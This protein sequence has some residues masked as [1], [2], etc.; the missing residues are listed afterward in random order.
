MEITRES[1]QEIK[2]ILRGESV[3]VGPNPNP[4]KAQ[5][6]TDAS[7][8]IK[9]NSIGQTFQGAGEYET[10][11]I[12]IDGIATGQTDLSYHIVHEGWHITCLVVETDSVVTDIILEK[13][14]PCQVLLLWV[15][16][17]TTQ[18]LAEIITRFETNLIVPV[19]I[20]VD[21]NELATALQLP[22]ETVDKFK[23]SL[24]DLQAD[25]QRLLII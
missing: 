7:Q 21:I 19:S 1:P 25:Q 13:L 3:S 12:M 9:S 18:A 8:T 24:K 4:A 23:L 22:V 15:K 6:G 20:P 2:L 14:Q 16:D 17:I 11:G 5:L 10:A